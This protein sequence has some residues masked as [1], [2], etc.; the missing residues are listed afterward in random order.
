M[1]QA[2]A[3]GAEGAGVDRRL[4]T[5]LY[6]QIYVVIRNKIYDGS[7]ADGSRVPSEHEV[8]A[9]Y[10]VSRITA[11]RALDELAAAGLVVR[12]RGRG[13]HV[14]FSAP[15]PPMRSSVEG[16]LEN[17]LLMGLKTEVELLD[18]A[19]VRPP[20]EVAR[21]LECRPEALVQRAVR[22]RSLEGA[23]FSHL[24][25]YV[26]EEVGRSYSRDDLGGTPLL[27]LLERS[28]VVISSAR[29]TIS[30]TLADADV[31]PLLGVDVATAL[32]RIARVVFDQKQRPVEHITGLYRPDRYQYS[33]TLSR[34]NGTKSRAWSPAA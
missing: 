30:A 24:T 21:E 13:T 11:K 1:R 5:P 18:F 33:M 34:V 29:Q 32:I 6:H 31:A 3:S 28:G 15:Q 2:G 25:T 16:L 19:Y 17:L 26:P 27:T 12:E 8:G 23:P 14:S 22:V 10:G 7:Y 20:A 4:L 9:L